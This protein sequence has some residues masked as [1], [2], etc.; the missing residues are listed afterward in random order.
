MNP[1]GDPDRFT[2]AYFHRLE[3][4]AEEMTEAGLQHEQT[5]GIEGP[6]WMLWQRWDN[7]SD[8]EAILE[9]AERTEAEPTLL[10]M[11]PHLLGV[12]KRVD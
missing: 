4:L 5:Y 7:P 9:V 1:N 2:T 8:R 11:N 10:G 3:D 12:A 6:A